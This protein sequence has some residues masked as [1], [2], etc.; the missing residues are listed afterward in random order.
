MKILL[1]SFTLL[2]IFG[3][4]RQDGVTPSKDDSIQRQEEYDADDF[5]EVPNN[6]NVGRGSSEEDAMSTE[7]IPTVDQ[8]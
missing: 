2:A 3:C 8:N 1:L 6:L 5:R 7:I 4:N